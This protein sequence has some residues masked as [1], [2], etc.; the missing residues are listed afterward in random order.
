[1]QISGT[2]TAEIEETNNENSNRY[3][4]VVWQYVQSGPKVTPDFVQCYNTQNL[5][6]L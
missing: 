6:Y 4:S 3:T 2:N 1:V 5:H